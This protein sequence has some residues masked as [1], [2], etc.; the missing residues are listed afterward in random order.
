M[1]HHLR[2]RLVE[3]T[4]TFAVV[5]CSGVGYQVH[6]TLNTFNQLGKEE[7]VM[8]HTHLVVREDAQLLYGFSQPEERSMFLLLLGVS[9]VGASTARMIL[10]A[11][12]VDQTSQAIQSGDVNAMKSVKGIGAK[13]AQRII[14]DLQD[15][16][17][18]IDSSALSSSGGLQSGHNNLQQEALIALT[19]LGFDRGRCEKVLGQIM[20]DTQEMTAVE[21]LIKHALKR[22]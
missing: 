20:K 12:N 18:A 22:L 16:L 6:I 4:P 8:L 5:E 1:I 3:K 2:G 11:M 17:G 19:T 7:N 13:T 15:K 14:I 21:D 9:G 10:S